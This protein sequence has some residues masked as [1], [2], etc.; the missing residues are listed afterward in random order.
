MS[1]RNGESRSTSSSIR[2][3][4]SS[5]PRAWWRAMYFSPPPA[6]RLVER[7]LQLGEAVQHGLPVL[8]VRGRAR[9]DGALRTGIEQ[10]LRDDLVHDL[11]GA[12]ADAH[13]PG[14]P[15]VTLHFGVLQ[16][17]GPA[18]QLDRRVDDVVARRHRGVL[19]H[20]HLGR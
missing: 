14:V 12:A 2:S 16:V 11:G 9:V 3:R 13:D 7:R 4:A 1:S 10:P 5:L 15:V 20:R 17:A 19:R 18:V 6:P 8:R